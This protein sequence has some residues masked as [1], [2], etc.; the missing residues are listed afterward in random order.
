[1]LCVSGAA[2]E[3]H[4]RTDE[5]LASLGRIPL[6]P[7]P[8]CALC[9]QCIYMREEFANTDA[10]AHTS[11]P[12]RRR[13]ADRQTDRQADRQ[14]D[15]DRQ[16]SAE[17]SVYRKQWTAAGRGEAASVRPK[18]CRDNSDPTRPEG[19]SAE[20]NTLA[21]QLSTALDPVRPPLLAISFGR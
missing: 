12:S 17:K 13:P 11:R 10:R 8:F 6:P 21:Q 3:L 20:V 19:R 7:H 2:V 1:M 4:F 18:S 9:T 14:I 16:F 5:H 15:K